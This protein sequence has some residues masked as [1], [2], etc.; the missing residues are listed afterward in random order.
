LWK[1]ICAGKESI[2]FFDDAEL[3]TPPPPADG[4]VTFV[5]ARSV[6]DRCEWFDAAF[7]GYGPRD[8][9]LMDPQHRVFL[10]CAWEALEHAGCDPARY[11]GNIGVVASCSLNTYLMYNVL[12]TRAAVNDLAQSFQVGGYQTLVGNDKDYVASRVA[13]KLNLRGPG[14]TVQSA[15][16]SSLVGIC[17]AAQNLASGLC[18][19]ALAG[20]VSITFPQKRGYPFV[21]GSIGSADGHC[22]PFDASAS[23][24]VFGSGVGIVVLK[25]LADAQADGDTIYAVLKG[26]A[27]NNDGGVR[28]G[29]MAPSAEGQAEVIRMALDRA[30]VDARTIG[31][32]ETHGTGTPLGDP[33]EVA[34]LTRAFRLSTPDTG[35]CALGSIKANIGHIESASGATGLIKAVLALYH[36]Q[37][38]PLLHFERPN[39]LIDLPSTPFYA[40]NQLLPWPAGQGPRRAGVSSFGVGGTNAHIVLEEAPAPAA[41][42]ETKSAYLLPLSARTDTALA[43]AAGNLATFL[44]QRGDRPLADVAYTLQTGRQALERRGFVVAGTPAEAI[45]ALRATSGVRGIKLPTTAPSV[46]FLF[47][48]QGS[49]H[50]DMGR[51]LYE[52]ESVFREHL[53]A[54]VEILRPLLGLDLRALLYPEP[55][56]RAECEQQLTQTQF[57]QPALFCIEYAL[58]RW[59][60]AHGVTPTAT[61][62]HSAGEYVGAVLAG[63]F[64]LEDALKV[65]VHRA[66]LMQAQPPGQML[67]VRLTESELQPWLTPDLALAAANAPGLHVVSGPTAAIADLTKRLEAAGIG[68][69][70]LQ[71]SHA[72]H[73]AMMEPALEPFRR[74]LESV[75][76]KPASGPFLSTRAGGWIAPDEVATVDYWVRQLRESVRFSRAVQALQA[77]PGT[78]FLE[79]GPSQALTTLALQHDD[80]TAPVTA[81]PSLRH[82]KE[83]LPDYASVLRAAGRLWQVGHAFDWT[84]FC[85]GQPP[86]RIALPTYPFE[87]KRYWIEPPKAEAGATPTALEM[88]A[89]P[90]DGTQETHTSHE[91]TPADPQE[92]ALNEVLDILQDLSGIDRATIVPQQAFLELGFDSLFLTQLSMAFQKK[93]LVKLTLRQMLDELSS[94]GA[95][96]AYVAAHRPSA[97]A[98]A[99]PAAEAAAGDKL[100]PAQAGPF[101][102]ETA[103]PPAPPVG[104]VRHGPF[105]PINKSAGDALT[106]KQQ[107]ALDALIARYTARTRRSKEHTQKHRAHFSDPRAVS[108]FRITWKEITY[109]VVSARSAGAKIWDLDDNEYIDVTMG[110]GTYL[111]GHNPEFIRLAIEAQLKEGF[112]IG[113]QNR[114]AGDVARMVCDLSGMDRATFCTTGSEAVMGAVRAARTVTGRN[115]VVYFSGDYHGVHEEVLAKGQPFQ[116]RTRT[117]PIAPG[118]PNE[119]VSQ[120]IVLPYGDPAALEA[121]RAQADDLA[122][123]LV[124]PVQSRKPELQPREFLHQLRALTQER[125]IALIFDEIVTGFR[126]H[127]GGSQAYYGIKADLATYG[128][129]IG[130]GMP[131]GVIA[132]RK[133]YLDAFDGGT[134]QYGDG[135][136]PEAGVTFFAGTFVR[137]PLAMAAARPSSS[138]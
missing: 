4:G 27:L 85:A 114:L 137:H 15:C 122:A 29:Y 113:P 94:P 60:M 96:A 67:A 1:N 80:P 132:G 45:A 43:A 126:I 87:R 46:V 24:T 17:Q 129:I 128:K 57:A 110:F 64:S 32:V 90:L 124:E 42:A 23:G 131:I 31:F 65:L 78:V 35:F 25:R 61:I 2:S 40:S 70:L 99:K 100:A 68:G 74:V 50:V 12:A 7:F 52:S 5:K 95:I 98:P 115:K 117:V 21:E 39:P 138:I 34:G 44:E 135:S 13:Y 20:G 75:T 37:I 77:Q 48:G 133:E 63:V 14:F 97:A 71:T 93:F 91:A 41:P 101:G 49:Q 73:S 18:D 125:G 134:W 116:G 10:E 105:A 54:C 127:Q 83:N 103:A 55:A 104:Q 16:S 102:P 28:A 53:D 19:I 119:L 33:I 86:R 72:F 58:A 47:P 107:Q 109:P 62:G 92:V 79:V 136:I 120:V 82:S 84:T 9:E 56:R 106:P 59:W 76:L 112:E 36:R 6:L 121:I 38:P 51:G 88:E 130:G 66:R 69:R 3:D 111:F 118:I 30:N 8:A 123:V 89:A 22:R 26:W 108:G 81:I 11:A